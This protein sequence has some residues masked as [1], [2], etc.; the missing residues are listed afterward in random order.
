MWFGK[1][2]NKY[3]PLDLLSQFTECAKHETLGNG[4]VHIVMYDAP[5][6]FCKPESAKRAF[7]FRTLT[8]Y[9]SRAN[10]L[11]ESKGKKPDP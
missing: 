7:A 5:E 1:A 9:V 2:Y 4:T 11:A 10:R 8:D 6:Q 3:I